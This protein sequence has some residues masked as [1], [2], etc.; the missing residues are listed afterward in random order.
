MDFL[1]LYFENEK[2][3]LYKSMRRD[4][5]GGTGRKSSRCGTGRDTKARETGWDG[6]SK[7]KSRGMGR[8]GTSFLSS[9]GALVHD[10]QSIMQQI[11]YRN[12]SV[13]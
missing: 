9:R 10:V 6:T 8:D 13:H 7:E 2:L 4:G 3:C 11:R 5:T 12:E 1:K